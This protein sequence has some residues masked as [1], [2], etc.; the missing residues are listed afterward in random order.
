MKLSFSS[1]L[2]NTV[3]CLEIRLFMSY[4][5]ICIDPTIRIGRESWCLPYAG[6]FSMKFGY[7]NFFLLYKWA[8]YEPIWTDFTAQTVILGSNLLVKAQTIPQYAKC[9]LFFFFTKSCVYW[10]YKIFEYGLGFWD[11]FFLQYWK[12]WKQQKLS[13]MY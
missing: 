4:F 13:E 1:V 2:K 12:M 9:A 3:W 6:F 11:M 8:K 5:Q 7:I 10:R